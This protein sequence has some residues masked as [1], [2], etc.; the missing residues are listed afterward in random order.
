[1]KFYTDPSYFFELWRQKMNVEYEKKRRKKKRRRNGSDG[2][3]RREGEGGRGEEG[4]R[5][6][7]EKEE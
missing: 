7:C 4:G 5:K 3:M 6:R 2:W 1:M